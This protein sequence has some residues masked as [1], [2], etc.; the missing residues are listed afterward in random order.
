MELRAIGL[1]FAV[2]AGIYLFF[3]FLGVGISSYTTFTK[4]QKTDTA[5]QFKVASLWSLYPTLAF[6]IIRSFSFIRKYFDSFYRGLDTSA[7]GKERAGWISIG[8]VIMLAS[9]AGMF[10]LMDQSVE[11]VC[12]PTKDEAQKFKDDMLKRAQETTPAVQS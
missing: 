12:I 9:V 5:K 11:A 3:L 10:S 1:L 7:S 8:Y 4:C 2:A 6:L